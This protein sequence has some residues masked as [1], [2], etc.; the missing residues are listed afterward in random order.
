M[1]ALLDVNVLIAL[2]DSDHSLHEPA[3]QWFAQRASNGWASSPITQ[4]GCVRIMA[5]PSY[6]NTLPVS[7]VMQRLAQACDSKL[8]EFWSDDVTL[9]DPRVADARKIHGSRQL[10]DVYLLAL[11]VRHKGQFVTFDGSI[12]T[13]AV[14]GA[15]KNH[16]LQL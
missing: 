4:N 16:L 13:D 1:R 5:H 6:S 2:L 11:A 7:A 12:A 3:A 8:H 14:V 9:L 15:N 10:T